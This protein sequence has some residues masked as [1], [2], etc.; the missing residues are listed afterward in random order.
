MPTRAP[1][2]SGPTLYTI[3]EAA[4]ELRLCRATIYNLIAAG[5]LRRVRIGTAVRIPAADL[6]ALIDAGME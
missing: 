6:A 3:R 1:L 2:D 4:A 5:K